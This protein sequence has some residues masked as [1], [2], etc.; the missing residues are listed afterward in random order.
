MRTI[1]VL[2]V[3]AGM[4]L[5]SSG[6]FADL[7]TLNFAGEVYAVG[8]ALTGD[9]V[10]VN[11]I[12]NGQIVYDTSAPPLPGSN[13]DYG[14]FNGGLFN[15]SIGS[16]DV[17]SV[18]GSLRTQNDQQ[19]GSATNPADGLTYQT[20]PG[21][22]DDLNGR[23]ATSWQ[24]GLRRENLSGQ[25]WPDVAAAPDLADWANVTLADINSAS[26]HWMQF[27]T[28]VNDDFFGDSQIRW[29]ITSFNVGSDS[30]QEPGGPGGP[31]P[32]PAS[33]SLLTMGLVGLAL[34]RRRK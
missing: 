19:N 9:G 3:L 15:I 21:T 30:A 20:S 8:D 32:E 13:A 7:I 28:D 34:R 27:T 11:D 17:T 10:A 23:T 24:F 5:C 12:V 1:K 2:M 4:L 22:S 16:F 25:L 14:V 18:S 31:I 26:W 29:N 6:V 33:L